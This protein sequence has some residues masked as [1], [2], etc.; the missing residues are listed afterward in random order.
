MKRKKTIQGAVAAMVTVFRDDESF[1][2]GRTKEHVDFLIE[3]EI[4]GIAVCASTGEFETMSDE[5]R[6]EIIKTVVHAVDGRVPIYAHTGSSTTRSTVNLSKY[7]E[8]N[9]ADGV[10]T[11][12]P[13]Y[14]IPTIDDILVFFEKVKESINIPIM[15]YDN[16]AD[17]G[18]TLS[19]E[20]VAKMNKEGF[21]S[22]IKV[23]TDEI[24][25][26]HNLKYYC[27]ENLKVFCGHDLYALEALMS[28]ADGWVSGILNLVPHLGV[29]LCN[30][31]EKK[32]FR[33]TVSIWNKILPLINFPACAD[34]RRHPHWLATIKTGL[35]LINRDVGEPRK[36]IHTLNDEYTQRLQRILNKIF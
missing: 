35:R 18:L 6:K 25:L 30:V 11:I 16:S 26:I 27:G 8:D 32:D 14:L 24:S 13:Y 19:A 5:E 17:T 7:A 9:G 23:F 1:D 12:T 33:A 15:L 34:N 31:A 28:G 29:E 3:N 20:T 22:S 21:V 10:I 2:A 36:P 4:D